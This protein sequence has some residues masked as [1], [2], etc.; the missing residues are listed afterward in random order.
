MLGGF[1]VA[2]KGSVL[3]FLV[4]SVVVGF[5]YWLGSNKSRKDAEISLCL[6]LSAYLLLF[7]RF[8]GCFVVCFLGWG[9]AW[10]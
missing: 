5:V 6:F 1:D 8:R 2:L 9:S 7:G 3:C 4:F 10:L